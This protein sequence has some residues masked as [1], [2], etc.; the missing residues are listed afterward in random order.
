MLGFGTVL[1]PDSGC[2]YFGNSP[3]YTCP[4]SGGLYVNLG[5]DVI[6][7]HRYGAGFDV[8][9]RG[10]QGNYENSGEPYRPVLWEF[11]GVYQPRVSKKFGVDLFGGIGVQSARFY[12]NGYSCVSYLYCTDYTS[13]NHFLI[14]LGGGVRYYFFHA[15]FVRPEVHY[16][17]I[18]GNTKVFSSSNVVRVG[19]SIGYTIGGPNH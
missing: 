13:S 2:G 9:W 15:L 5:G 16:Y 10:G 3:G 19:A 18:V 12:T 17:Y 4:E 8:A 11:N 14:G 6:F 1:S 7:N